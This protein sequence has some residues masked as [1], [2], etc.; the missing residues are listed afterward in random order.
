MLLLGEGDIF[1]NKIIKA[2][3]V[4]FMT[5]NSLFAM[6]NRNIRQE[7]VVWKEPS[8][9]A[10]KPMKKKTYLNGDVYE[11]ETSWGRAEGQGTMI[12]ANKSEF[13]GL[14][15]KDKP[16]KGK[17]KYTDGAIFD[18]ILV[19][20]QPFKGKMLYPDGSIY[21]GEFKGE[22]PDGHGEIEYPNGSIYIG[23]FA[24]G[25]LEGQGFYFDNERNMASIG[26]FHNGE[27]HGFGEWHAETVTESRAEIGLFD[28]GE[29]INGIATNRRRVK[30][31]IKNRLPK[32]NDIYERLL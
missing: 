21:N 17:M 5:A 14:F 9:Q 4:G 25:L 12:F 23:A 20:G 7:G 18:G 15:Q 32:L 28:A 3:L 19:E 11:G 10:Q 16:I 6:Q 8:M 27:M 1:V 24:H 26:L 29:L 30:L 2:S 13:I 31:V 22:R